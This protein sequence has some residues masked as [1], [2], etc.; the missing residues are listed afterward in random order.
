MASELTSPAQRREARV[1]LAMLP[2][3]A[4]TASISAIALISVVLFALA[5]PFRGGAWWWHTVWA[6]L[7]ALVALRNM[8]AGIALMA[9]FDWRPAPLVL[10]TSA[11][12]VAA[13]PGWWLD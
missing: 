5:A 6:A 12:I 4:I 9:T 11:L 8:R 1:A 13:W 7:A 2:F 10:A 3:G